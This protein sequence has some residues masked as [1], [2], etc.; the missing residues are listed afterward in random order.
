MHVSLH[1][2]PTAAPSLQ[3]RRSAG[4]R[5]AAL[6]DQPSPQTKGDNQ[7]KLETDGPTRPHPQILLPQHCN[8]NIQNEIAKFA[9]SLR[10]KEAYCLG[11]IPA[12]AYTDAQQRGRLIVELENDEPCGFSLW[13]QRGNT[14]RIHQTAIVEDARRIQ[15]ATTLVTHL[16]NQPA[17]KR[18]TRLRLR[19][20]H[21]LDA[22]H[23]W[24]AIGCQIVGTQPGGKTWRRTINLYELKLKKRIK[25]AESL[26]HGILDSQ[27]KRLVQQP[28]N[29]Q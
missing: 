13:A 3:H 5:L 27:Q 28:K 8:S 6:A 22:N 11:F 14:L 1:S 20:A 24:K 2:A 16:L 7:V 26:I 21:D 10:K 23:F 29:R 4:N 25:T 9:E 12:I 18:C 17:A 15:H 19:V